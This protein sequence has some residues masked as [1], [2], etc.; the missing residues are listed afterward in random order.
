MKYLFSFLFFLGFTTFL[1]GQN[2][3]LD[4]TTIDD[5]YRE[6]QFYISVTYNLLGNKPD[7]VSQ[8]GFSSG[9]HLGFIRDMPINKNRNV[10]VGLGFGLSTNS[11]NQTLLISKNTDQTL[12]YSILDKDV[13]PFSKN[14]FTTYLLEFPFELRWRTSNPVDYNFWRIYAGFKLGYLF[15]N[16]SK[17]KGSNGDIIISNL[18][19]FNK[20]HYGLS[21]SIGYSNF[22]GY[23]YYALNDIFKKEAKVNDQRLAMNAFKIGLIYYIL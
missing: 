15:Y 13:T 9:F 14:K 20:F 21:V 19:D 6:D 4:S 2:I 1:F 17:H 3:A 7:G 11:Y 5:K 23:V 18:N 10:A 22:N 8:N 12:A 16:S